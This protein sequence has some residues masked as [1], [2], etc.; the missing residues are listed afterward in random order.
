[1]ANVIDHNSMRSVIAFLLVALSACASYEP[2]VPPAYVGPTAVIWDR[3]EQEGEFKG[4]LFYLEAVDGKLVESSEV[5]TRRAT[6][7]KGFQIDMRTTH[8]RVPAKQLKLRIVATHVTG[9]PIHA[10][11]SALT[12]NYRS[13]EGELVFT[14]EEDRAYI[15]AGTLV[16]D[17]PAVWIADWKTGERVSDKVTAKP[18]R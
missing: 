3:M 2:S 5:L 15:V 4:Q 18:R 8:H 6:Y 10:F 17:G 9:A 14:P 16:N 1:M 11:V 13:V 7:G 12:G